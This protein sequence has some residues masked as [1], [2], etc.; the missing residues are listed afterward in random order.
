MKWFFAVFFCLSFVF[1]L[2]FGVNCFYGYLFP[3]KFNEEVSLAS[4]TF[5]VE[6]AVVYS[7]INIES[8]F[9]RVVISSKGAT[10]LMQVMPS[11]AAEAAK[12]LSFEGFDLLNPEDNIFIGTYY[13]SK[14][15]DR[16]KNLETAL[17]A[18]NAGP[19]NVASWL[20][21]EIYSMDGISLNEIPFQETKNYIQKFHQNYK[22]YST[23]NKLSLIFLL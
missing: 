6:E 2:T 7:V 8:R 13:L 10:G 18:Y 15:I 14:M 19:S 23:K 17:C 20:K 4:E 12:E 21:N 16:F 3:V 1:L 11:T 9:N 5:N 22:Y